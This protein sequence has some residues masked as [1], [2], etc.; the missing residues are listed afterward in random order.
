MV[1][2][3]QRHQ[4]VARRIIRHLAPRQVGRNAEADFAAFGASGG[5]HEINVGADRLQPLQPR[6]VLFHR[7]E[8][9][10]VRIRKID[11]APLGP[12]AAGGADVEDGSGRKPASARRFIPAYIVVVGRSR[13]GLRSRLAGTLA[14]N[15]IKQLRIFFI[16]R[17]QMV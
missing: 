16:I 9:E 6:T 13:N 1:N 7:F 5:D 8:E 17:C 3:G 2:G 12:A 4:P 14:E 11:L 10:V 15:G